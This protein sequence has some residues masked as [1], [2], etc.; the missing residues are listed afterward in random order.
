[1]HL[2]FTCTDSRKSSEVRL[3]DIKNVRPRMSRLSEDFDGEE[4]ALKGEDGGFVNILKE[5][6]TLRSSITSDRSSN[7]NMFDKRRHNFRQRR[8]HSLD[9]T[10]KRLNGCIAEEGQTHG[11]TSD[12]DEQN[13]NGDNVRNAL[14]AFDEMIM[15]IDSDSSD[16]KEDEDKDCILMSNICLTEHEGMYPTLSKDTRTTCLP[17]EVELMT[18]RK[19]STA[20]TD[21]AQSDDERDVKRSESF[22]SFG[23]SVKIVQQRQ[24]RTT[25]KKDTI[26]SINLQR[27]QVD[28]PV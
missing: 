28:V 25:F 16:S 13:M 24:V 22:A 26:E 2:F 18:M 3:E 4:A 14:E 7:H 5:E 9:D 15:D 23:S 27:G 17:P 19:S 8:K 10:S 21:S 12:T 11:R 20:S 1:M 6:K